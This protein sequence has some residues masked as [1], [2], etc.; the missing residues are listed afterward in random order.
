[1]I[2]RLYYRRSERPV[3]NCK[4]LIKIDMGTREAFFVE[5]SGSKSGYIVR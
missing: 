3:G 1:M 2:C 4:K 5:T